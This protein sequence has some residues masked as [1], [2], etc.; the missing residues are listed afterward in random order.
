MKIGKYSQHNS[1]NKVEN[2]EPTQVSCSTI[3]QMV[4]GYQTRCQAPLDLLKHSVQLIH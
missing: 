1:F 4:V 3:K 2:L